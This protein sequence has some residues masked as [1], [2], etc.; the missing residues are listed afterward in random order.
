MTPADRFKK[1]L[2]FQYKPLEQRFFR[3]CEAIK[4]PELINKYKSS[5]AVTQIAV[6]DKYANFL[7]L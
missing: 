6:M 2:S 1:M 3:D 4:R 7:G 5:N